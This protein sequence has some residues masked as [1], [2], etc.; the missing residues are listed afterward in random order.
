MAEFW[1]RWHISLSTW[2]R[3]YVYIPLGGSRTGKLG[4]LRNVFVVFLVSGLWHGANWTYV[5]WGLINALMFVPLLLFGWNRDNL[6][7]VAEG[8]LLPSAREAASI[9]ATFAL[10]CF[11]W[12]YFR[13]KTV[14]D[15]NDYLYRMFTSGEFQLPPEYLWICPLILFLVS[16]E[17]IN[18]IDPFPEFK[19][20]V[21]ALNVLGYFCL[22][23]ASSF[24]C[25]QTQTFIYFQF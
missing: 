17:W 7:E 4:S 3:D 20:K 13:S 23:Y 11:A 15:A 5:I 8:R 24:F 16:F 12:I 6:D 21:P 1:R 19:F 14:G 25:P 10:T 22:I 2:F 18:R 9:F